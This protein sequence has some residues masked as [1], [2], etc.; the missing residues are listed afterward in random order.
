ME[1]T[2]KTRHLRPAVGLGLALLIGQPSAQA[3][4]LYADDDTTVTGN[5]L[6]VYGMINSRKNYEGSQGGST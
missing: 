4:E 6:A 5:F 3:I 2:R 1:H